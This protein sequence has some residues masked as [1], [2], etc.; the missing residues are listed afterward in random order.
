MKEETR[1]RK[2]M[3]ALGLA[4]VHQATEAK[5]ANLNMPVVVDE[6]KIDDFRAA[7]GLIYFL[8][9]PELFSLKTCKHCGEDFLVSRQY[10]ACCSYTCIRKDLEERG[11]K[12]RAGEDIEALVQ[13]EVY[14]GNEPL[15]VRNLDSVTRALTILQASLS[16]QHPT[17]NR[18]S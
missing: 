11:F 9:A 5:K 2:M 14:E 16:E 13:S 3:E 15:W 1:I 4:D 7:Q 12:W 18:A 6:A 17:H 10:V 8:R